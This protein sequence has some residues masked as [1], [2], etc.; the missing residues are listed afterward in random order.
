MPLFQLV[1]HSVNMFMMLVGRDVMM[2]APT[3]GL[4]FIK[5]D[6]LLITVLIIKDVQFVARLDGRTFILTNATHHIYTLAVIDL[7]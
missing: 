4:I 7:C 3:S 1:A 5:K 2:G 6:G